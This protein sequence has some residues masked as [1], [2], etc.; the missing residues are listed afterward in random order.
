MCQPTPTVPSR[1]RFSRRSR[2]GISAAP[3]RS[4]GGP[5]NCTSRWPTCRDRR[6]SQSRSTR[7]ALRT[8]CRGM[9]DARRRSARRCSERSARRCRRRSRPQ[10][11]AV[12]ARADDARRAVRRARASSSRRGPPHPRPRRLSPRAGA[13]HRG[14]F[15]HPRLRRRAGATARRAPRQAV[16]AERHRRHAALVQLRGVRG[17]VRVHVHAP[18]AIERL[19]PWAEPGS[20]GYRGAFLSAYRTAMGESPVL[21]RDLT[22]SISCSTAFDPGQGALRTRLRVEHRPEWVRIPLTALVTAGVALAECSAA[23]SALYNAHAAL[24]A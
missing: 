12:L 24:T 21:P 17:A 14:G 11:D 4:A 5:R 19:E 13:A 9:P 2:A 16:A 15:R 8:A 6:S 22:P 23:A 10:A 1:R 7:P 3:R 20:I 18:G